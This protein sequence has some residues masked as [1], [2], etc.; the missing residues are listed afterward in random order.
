MSLLKSI[1]SSLLSLGKSSGDFET[2]EHNGYDQ[3][4]TK[5][6]KWQYS[7]R[8]AAEKKLGGKIWDGLVVHHRDGNKKNNRSS[9][10]SVMSRKKHSSLHAKKKR[11]SF[12]WF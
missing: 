9:N 4:R 12:D 6:G 3:F 10:L 8:R 1:F 11:K 5:K 2:R 7:H